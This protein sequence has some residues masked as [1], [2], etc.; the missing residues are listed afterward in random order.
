MKLNEFAGNPDDFNGR[1]NG[2]DGFNGYD[3][4]L[5]DPYGNGYNDEPV[6]AGT[7]AV[8][9]D[10]EELAIVGVTKD[11]KKLAIVTHGGEGHAGT[12]KPE[13][14]GA[15]IVKKGQKPQ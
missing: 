8:G 6:E 4:Y 12:V 10:D 9:E 5:P 1:G 11:G 2:G 14:F 3:V 13:H 7:V 15:V